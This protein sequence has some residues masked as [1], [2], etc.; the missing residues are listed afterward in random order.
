MCEVGNDVFICKNL[1]EKRLL[2]NY[3]RKYYSYFYID[4]QVSV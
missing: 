3:L 2:K 1:I 4:F